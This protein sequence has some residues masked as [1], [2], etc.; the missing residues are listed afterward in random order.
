MNDK[1]YGT[2]EKVIIRRMAEWFCR[3]Q[4]SVEKVTNYALND[5]NDDDFKALSQIAD[6]V[7]ECAMDWEYSVTDYDEDIEVEREDEYYD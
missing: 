7:R 4:L 3:C 2:F 6:K 5:M 1:K